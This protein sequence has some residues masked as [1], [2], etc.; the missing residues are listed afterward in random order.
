[1]KI[2]V[3]YPNKIHDEVYFNVENKTFDEIWNA[4]V[5]KYEVLENYTTE[6]A[7]FSKF[8]VF[9]NGIRS[10]NFY[11]RCNNE[12]FYVIVASNKIQKVFSFDEKFVLPKKCDKCECE[13]VVYLDSEHLL[14]KYTNLC[15]ECFNDLMR[16][17]TFENI[18]HKNLRD[19]S[20][21]DFG[22]S[23]ER[24][25]T[26]ALY[27]L[28]KYKKIYKKD[29]RI[30]CIFNAIGLGDYDNQRKSAAEKVF[31]TFCSKKDSFCVNELNI[32]MLSDYEKERD[33]YKGI[34]AQYCNLC[35]R[36]NSFREYALYNG[37][38]LY[39]AT[40][41]GTVE[42]EYVNKLMNRGESYPQGIT[43]SKVRMFDNT[44]RI[45]VLQ[46]VSED[47]LSLYA[48]LN[49]VNY[50]IADC[51][52]CNVSPNYFC[53]GFA[54]NS[55]KATTNWVNNTYGDKT[56]DENC[57]IFGQVSNNRRINMNSKCIKSCDGN[58]RIT[59][60]FTVKDVLNSENNNDSDIEKFY[61]ELCSNN[62]E[63]W[64]AKNSNFKKF[65][66]LFKEPD[67]QMLPLKLSNNICITFKNDIIFKLDVNRDNIEILDLNK[68]EIKILKEI[69]D[70]KET[71][72]KDVILEI[73]EAEYPE[74]VKAIQCLSAQGLIKIGNNIDN[75]S[76]MERSL[77]IID[78]EQMIE[79]NYKMIIKDIFNV[80]KNENYNY[81][82]DKIYDLSIIN[83]NSIV[84]YISSS[85]QKIKDF[86]EECKAIQNEFYVIYIHMMHPMIV[87]TNDLEKITNNC[88]FNLSFNLKVPSK[89]VI[90]QYNIQILSI[91]SEIKLCDRFIDDSAIN[92]YNVM[93]YTNIVSGERKKQIF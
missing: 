43:S 21:V 29:F 82:Q 2:L 40:G 28:T 9:R 75:T 33:N 32:P 31:N 80:E 15:L 51:P 45:L 10:Y 12:D 27:F 69:M 7:F 61:Y 25:S 88:D 35:I 79:D 60:G 93:Y 92:N 65:E 11:T 17:K 70:N 22:I 76:K 66:E 53:R 50:C 84:I 26:L 42:D 64:L 68:Y 6:K 5:R 67:V 20:V 19:G 83:K 57:T 41:S 91:L 13:N 14:S 18:A 78:E 52:L 73:T 49:N 46:G 3:H 63:N 90:K 74:Y 37:V 86:Y 81:F 55:I 85:V 24:D 16:S 59:G 30:S 72:I 77:Y 8:I 56:L 23:G 36:A 39:V 87:F 89:E 38:D 34:T 47:M 4:I 48:A 71:K 58:K 54:L 44:R 62:K 1:M